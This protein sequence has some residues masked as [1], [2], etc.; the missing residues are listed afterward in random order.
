MKNNQV[1]V[2]SQGLAPLLFDV[3]MLTPWRYLLPL[4]RWCSEEKTKKEGRKK[5]KR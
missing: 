4:F 2:Q 1:L 5:E 3:E